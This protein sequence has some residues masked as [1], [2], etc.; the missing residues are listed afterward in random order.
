VYEGRG[1]MPRSDG[2]CVDYVEVVCCNMLMYI[3]M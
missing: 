2:V 3:W 1:R